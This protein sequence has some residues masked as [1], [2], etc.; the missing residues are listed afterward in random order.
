MRSIFTVT[1]LL[2]ALVLPALSCAVAAVLLTAVPSVARVW[3]AGQVAM[4]EVASL[5]LKATATLPRYQPLAFAVVVAAALIVGAVASR[6]RVGV[7]LLALPPAL[8]ALQA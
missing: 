5:Q 7:V 1:T 8:V 2:G 3:V 6:L 4:P